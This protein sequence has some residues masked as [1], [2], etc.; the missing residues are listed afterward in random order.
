MMHNDDD[1]D[2]DND[3]QICLLNS[4]YIYVHINMYVCVWNKIIIITF[5]F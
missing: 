5:N 2:D 1:D 4:K 3:E